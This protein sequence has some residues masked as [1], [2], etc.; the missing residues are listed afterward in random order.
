MGVR[1][2]RR[3]LEMTCPTC[4]APL[5]NQRGFAD[6]QHGDTDTVATYHETCAPAGWWLDTA[7]EH[8]D[9][10]RRTL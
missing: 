1:S 3:S 10:H 4:D 7:Q 8:A 2:T 9:L 6:Y 5:D